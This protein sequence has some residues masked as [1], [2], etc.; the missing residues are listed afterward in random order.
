MVDWRGNAAV[1]LLQKGFSVISLFLVVNTLFG[2]SIGSSLWNDAPFFRKL[3][4]GLSMLLC[5]SASLVCGYLS[6]FVLKIL[7][8]ES[9]LIFAG[10]IVFLDMVSSVFTRLTTGRWFA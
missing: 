2:M 8:I 4:V 1:C 7:P 6:V 3:G 5:V 9:E 10:T